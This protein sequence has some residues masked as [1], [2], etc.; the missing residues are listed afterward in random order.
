MLNF[1]NLKIAPI[2]ATTDFLISLEDESCLKLKTIPS[3]DQGGYNKN[4]INSKFSN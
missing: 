3:P 4:N 1:C 2:T